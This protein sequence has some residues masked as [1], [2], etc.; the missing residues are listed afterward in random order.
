MRPW[1]SVPKG[2]A[3][4][5]DADRGAASLFGAGAVPS[6]VYTVDGT[7]IRPVAQRLPANGYFVVPARSTGKGQGI[8]LIR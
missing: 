1:G 8:A 6:E 7:H 4:R 3:S 5:S 2:F